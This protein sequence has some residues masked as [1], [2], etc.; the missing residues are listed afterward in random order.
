MEAEFLNVDRR[1][2]RGDEAIDLFSQLCKRRLKCGL[3]HKNYAKTTLG[4]RLIPAEERKTVDL[5]VEIKK[6]GTETRI[7]SSERKE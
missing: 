1:T 7:L 5:R 6:E 3:L 4:L 2:E